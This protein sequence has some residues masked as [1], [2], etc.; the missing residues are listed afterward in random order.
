MVAPHGVTA[1][2]TECYYRINTEYIAHIVRM[3]AVEHFFRGGD[4]LTNGDESKAEERQKMVAFMEEVQAA[5]P[6]STQRIS[7][8]GCPVERT[9]FAD[10]VRT[11]LAWQR[12]A[13]LANAGRSRVKQ[14]DAGEASRADFLYTIEEMRKRSDG[15]VMAIS[16]SNAIDIEG[17]REFPIFKV[18]SAASSA[19]SSARY[20]AS[21]R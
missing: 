18:D 16:S 5:A 12:Y 14:E 20:L 1:D 6:C 11:L 13:P 2:N 8:T 9:K 19:R 7:G 15:L 17:S 10:D 3:D 4:G 21:V